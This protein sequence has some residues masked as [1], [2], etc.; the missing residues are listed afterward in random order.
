VDVR[1]GGRP[2][3]RRHRPGARLTVTDGRTVRWI[4]AEKFAG[5]HPVLEEDLVFFDGVLPQL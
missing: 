5:L 4:T 1:A 2:R 3:R